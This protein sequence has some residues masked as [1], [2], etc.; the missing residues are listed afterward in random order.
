MAAFIVSFSLSSSAVFHPASLIT[1]SL[2]RHP[3]VIKLHEIIATRSSIYLIMEYAKGGDLFSEISRHRPLKEGSALILLAAYHDIETTKGW[4]KESNFALSV[5][6]EQ[7]N[8]RLLHTTCGT[9]MFSA[10]EVMTQ[11]GY[12]RASANAWSCGVILFLLLVD[13][14]PFGDSDIV[15]MHRKMV[16]KKF[17]IP[18]WFSQLMKQ[19]IARLLDPSL[20]L[21]IYT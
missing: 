5:P 8:N 20:E 3:N 1:Y 19:V 12:E 18:T 7:L 17:E 2:P 21:V 6:S 15:L 14:L 11:K 16:Q 9:L 13:Y 10:L 4:L